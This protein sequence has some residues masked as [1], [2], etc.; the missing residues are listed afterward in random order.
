MMWNGEGVEASDYDAMKWY[1]DAAAVGNSMAMHKLGNACMK[2]A[3]YPFAY[4]KKKRLMK[5]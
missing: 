3:E 4:M 1:M 2:H 5:F